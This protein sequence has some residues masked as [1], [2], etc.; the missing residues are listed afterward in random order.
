M[1]SK[2][3]KAG[4]EEGIKNVSTCGSSNLTPLTINIWAY[5]WG[6]IETEKLLT[7]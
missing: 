4:M 7:Y 6:Y 3:E 2:E 1:Y 5:F